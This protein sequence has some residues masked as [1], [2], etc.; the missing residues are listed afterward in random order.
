MRDSCGLQ[1]TP[2]AFSAGGAQVV[3]LK[4]E[5]QAATRQ[6]KL[7]CGARDVAAM[8][9]QGFGYHAALYFCERVRERHAFG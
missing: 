1:A 3:A 4:F 8:L 6:P 2:G 9:A 7:A 5:V